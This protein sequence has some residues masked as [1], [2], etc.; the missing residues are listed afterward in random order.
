MASLAA[1]SSP[2]RWRR[3]VVGWNTP[4]VGIEMPRWMTLAGLLALV[5]IFFRQEALVFIALGIA[6]LALSLRLWWDFSL[7]AT[8]YRRSFSSR[9]AFHGDEV[10]VMLETTNLKPL[11]VTR[12]EVAED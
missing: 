11:P 4:D 10:T 12:L 6:V 9:R 7:V 3:F 8:T 2:S 5:G 1:S